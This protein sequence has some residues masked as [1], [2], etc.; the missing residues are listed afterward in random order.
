MIASLVCM[1]VVGYACL[2]NSTPNDHGRKGMT[3]YMAQKYGGSKK[4][5]KY[6]KHKRYFK[7]EKL[8]YFED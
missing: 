5:R 1:W 4:K 7:D 6:T 8:D 3:N 2:N